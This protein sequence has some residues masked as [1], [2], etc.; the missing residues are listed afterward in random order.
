MFWL[1]LAEVLKTCFLG[2]GSYAKQFCD[3]FLFWACLK[4]LLG[5]ILSNSEFFQQ[6]VGSYR[7]HALLPQWLNFNFVLVVLP[8]KNEEK[9]KKFFF[10]RDT[11]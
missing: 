6:F 2:R 3:D 8:T 10:S 4:S 5:M 11:D 1:V 7:N 9:T